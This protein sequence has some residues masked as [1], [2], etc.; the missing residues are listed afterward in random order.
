M[1]HDAADAALNLAARTPGLRL[2]GWAALG[3]ALPVEDRPAMDTLI[4]QRLEELPIYDRLEAAE[5]LGTS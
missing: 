1:N 4:N 5:R 2:P 3:F